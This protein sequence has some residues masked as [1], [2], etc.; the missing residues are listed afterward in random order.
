MLYI[1]ICYYIVKKSYLD[2][3]VKF[4]YPPPSLPDNKKKSCK[5]VLGL[6]NVESKCCEKSSRFLGAEIKQGNLGNKPGNIGKF[7]EINETSDYSIEIRG[8]YMEYVKYSMN[9][10]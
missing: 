7:E 5:S 4:R 10:F 1:L 8:K 9:Q 3:G 2:P 6:H